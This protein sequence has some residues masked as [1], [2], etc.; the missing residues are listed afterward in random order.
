MPQSC[1]A[2]ASIVNPPPAIDF[3]RYSPVASR[4]R[5]QRSFGGCPS[6]EIKLLTTR[7]WNGAAA[8]WRRTG[9]GRDRDDSPFNAGSRRRTRYHMATR[10]QP[11]RPVEKTRMLST[12]VVDGDGHC[13]R[14]RPM[15]G[16]GQLSLA[17][18]APPGEWP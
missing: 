7:S 17:V 8:S 16:R 4:R 6:Q 2:D 13:Q 3:S 14:R 9:S 5:M 1:G 12:D 15:T 18:L 11:I 10:L